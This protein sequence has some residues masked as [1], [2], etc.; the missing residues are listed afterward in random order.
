MSRLKTLLVILGILLLGSGIFLAKNTIFKPEPPKPTQSTG[1]ENISKDFPSEKDRD[2]LGGDV[3]G[4]ETDNS[5]SSKP[6]SYDSVLKDYT[7]SN[8]LNFSKPSNSNSTSPYTSN[9]NPA[10]TQNQPTKNYS[11]LFFK[12]R[13]AGSAAETSLTRL[14]DITNNYK[15][16]IA[17]IRASCAASNLSEGYCDS[18]VQ[19]VLNLYKNSATG[20]MRSAHDSLATAQSP[21]NEFRP[22][23]QNWQTA[24]GHIADGLIDLAQA[25]VNAQNTILDNNQLANTSN[26]SSLIQSWK[27]YHSAALSS[28]P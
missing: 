11:T 9:P 5:T 10:S 21:L 22:V 2:E 19:G 14:V 23:P 7:K 17:S 20:L 25:L 8:P 12:L 4:E 6:S 3:K 24:Y 16:Q 1:F 27:S 26:L 15:S 28:A 18:Q 13:T